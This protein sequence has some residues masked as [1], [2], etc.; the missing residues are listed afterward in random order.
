M[1]RMLV[2]GS[3]IGL[4]AVFAGSIIPTPSTLKLYSHT[5]AS[6][7]GTVTDQTSFVPLVIAARPSFHWPCTKT[8]EALGARTRKVTER[9][10]AISGERTGGVK[11]R[12]GGVLVEGAWA[13]T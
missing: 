5:P 12:R 8:S 1:C 11:F 7:A 13:M 2:R 6:I 9:S 3:R 10:A 4:I